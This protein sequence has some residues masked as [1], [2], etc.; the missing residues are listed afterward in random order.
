[1][2]GEVRKG[3][4]QKTEKVPKVNEGEKEEWKKKEGR[5]FLV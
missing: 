3:K 1:M 5:K 2:K 4:K